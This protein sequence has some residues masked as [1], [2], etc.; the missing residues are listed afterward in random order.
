MRLSNAAAT[1]S[2]QFTAAERQLTDAKVFE[3]Q[4]S[5]P[6]EPIRVSE[7]PMSGGKL[8]SENASQTPC[9]QALAP[10]LGQTQLASTGQPS[11]SSSFR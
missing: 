7:C 2:V 4:A 1:A 9:H 11:S 5:Q 8:H 10:G 6:A 3:L